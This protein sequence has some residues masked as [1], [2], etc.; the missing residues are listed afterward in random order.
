MSSY[1]K[2]DSKLGTCYKYKKNYTTKKEKCGEKIRLASK[3][4]D[5]NASKN[6]KD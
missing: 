6:V 2:V 3:N 5:F 1:G 4:F